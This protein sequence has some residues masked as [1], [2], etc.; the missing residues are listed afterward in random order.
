[1]PPYQAE[2]ID[3]ASP[4]VEAT[5]APSLPDRASDM[6]PK[7]A[8]E[9]VSVFRRDTLIYAALDNY[10]E[11]AH[12]TLGPTA[13]TAQHAASVALQ[14][15][16]MQT[17]YAIKDSLSKDVPLDITECPPAILT[18]FA[19]DKK[20]STRASREAQGT[21]ECETGAFEVPVSP[22]TDV[23]PKKALYEALATQ[24]S[25]F[26]RFASKTLRRIGVIEPY[27]PGDYYARTIKLHKEHMATIAH[28]EAQGLPG[29]THD[30]LTL[31]KAALINLLNSDPAERFDLVNA[32]QAMT[33]ADRKELQA[34]I[35]LVNGHVVEEVES[36]QALAKERGRRRAV[37]AI[38]SGG[39]MR[40]TDAAGNLI[41]ELPFVESALVRY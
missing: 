38:A 31:I 22:A 35:S 12:L 2:L 11:E 4:V 10:L 28:V 7:I 33:D 23:I 26:W 39:F 36:F 5:F 37:K 34:T 17:T 27:V 29:Y 14:R 9:L 30:E 19:F 18:T 15:I 41:T 21:T 8:A 1:M 20:A 25:R 40:L 13:V 16:K 3:S 32:P 24:P 6:D